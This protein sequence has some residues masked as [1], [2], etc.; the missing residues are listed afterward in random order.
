MRK[1]QG[2]QA[3][4]AWMVR[5]EICLNNWW[6]IHITPDCLALW[7]LFD[8]ETKNPTWLRRRD[9]NF[10]GVRAD[11]RWEPIWCSSSCITA[12]V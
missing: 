11:H 4:Q 2:I 10:S 9:Q 6:F 12:S 8:V 1:K 7:D 5:K 3:R